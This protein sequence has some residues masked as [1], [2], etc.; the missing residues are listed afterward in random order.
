M[1]DPALLGAE[2]STYANAFTY[3]GLPL[4]RQI[5]ANVDALVMGVPYDLGTSARAGARN[6]PGGIRQASVQLRW[7]EKRWP[8]RFAL[9]ETINIADYGDLDF[10]AGD[11]AG[12]VDAVV[13]HADRILSADKYLLTLGGDHF[14]SLPVLRA[15]ARQ[16]PRI[17]LVHFDAHTDTE[18]SQLEFY[19]GSMF[20]VAMT[21]GLFEPD[22]STQIG[23][24]TEYDYDSHQLSVLDADY[25]NEHSVDTIVEKIVSRCAGLPVYLSIDIDCLDPAFAPG[26]GTPVSGG[27]STHKLLSIIRQLEP[28]H[29]IAADVMEVAPAYDSAEITA[30]AAATLG[31]ELLYLHAASTRR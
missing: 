9:K 5:D 14:V 15:A 25:A 27:L 18:K 16:F 1:T 2:S 26:T 8:W 30:L 29:I 7:E 3:L 24:R 11:S 6:G 31:L 13:D 22:H 17:A 4:S 20:D 10:G 19:H 21:E 28:L 23:I 12:M